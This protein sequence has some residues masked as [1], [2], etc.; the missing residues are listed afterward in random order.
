MR[1]SGSGAANIKQQT[2]QQK[3]LNESIYQRERNRI[4]SDLD[5]DENPQNVGEFE[6]LR[7]IVQVNILF[8]KYLLVG[9]ELLNEAIKLTLLNGTIFLAFMV[10]FGSL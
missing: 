7:N 5:E 6:H 4:I 1:R 2:L 10:Q 8:F 3:S 9:F